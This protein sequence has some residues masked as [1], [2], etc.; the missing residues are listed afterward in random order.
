MQSLLSRVFCIAPGIACLGYVHHG[1]ACLVYGWLPIVRCPSKHDYC[2][3]DCDRLLLYLL[4]W[5]L[6]YQASAHWLIGMP[7]YILVVVP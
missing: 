2:K 3:T 5:T 1:I 7:V 6:N 4:G